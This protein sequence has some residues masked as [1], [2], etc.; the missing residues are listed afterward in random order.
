MLIC[1]RTI[2]F[3]TRSRKLLFCP[4][5]LFVGLALFSEA[6]DAECLKD[7]NSVLGAKVPAGYQCLP[8]RWKQS[9]LKA[10]FF[11][12]V[13]RDGTVSKDEAMLYSTLRDHMGDQ[14]LDA[15]FEKRWTPKCG[16]RGAGNAANGMS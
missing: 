10:P 13:A 5:L 15:G 12:R 3:L 16:R 11:R 1:S 2:F 9:K 4:L 6:F 7:A 8:M 14:S